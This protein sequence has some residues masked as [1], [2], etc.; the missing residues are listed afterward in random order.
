MDLPRISFDFNRRDVGKLRLMVDLINREL[1][2][3]AEDGELL[4]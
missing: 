3:T 2:D 4:P 1:G